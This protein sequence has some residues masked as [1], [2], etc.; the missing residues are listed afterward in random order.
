VLEHLRSLDL[1]KTKVSGGLLAE[2]ITERRKRAMA[3]L[4]KI[5]AELKTRNGDSDA[6]PAAE[7]KFT[8][9]NRRNGH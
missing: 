5:E 8:E 3:K 6:A 2:P 9:G 1:T 4:R 7:L